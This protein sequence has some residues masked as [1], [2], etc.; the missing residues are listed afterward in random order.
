MTQ[1]SFLEG[2]VVI[3]LPDKSKYTG[4]IKK[5][6]NHYCFHGNGIIKFINGDSYE[7]EWKNGQMDGQGEYKWMR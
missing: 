6:K 3:E 7:G 4:D 1:R 5:V 2:S